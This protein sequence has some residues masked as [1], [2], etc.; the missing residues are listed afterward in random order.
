M[1]AADKAQNIL[2]KLE[3]CAEKHG[4]DIVDVE[5]AG[6]TKAP[7][8]RVRIDWADE[9]R[10]SISLDEVASETKWISEALDEFD[11]F[12]GAYTLEVS[13]PGLDRPLRRE[14]DF[15]RFAGSDVVLTTN[16]VEGRKK[17]T[18]KL[19]GL[20]DGKVALTADDGEHTFALSDIKRCCIKPNFAE[21]LKTK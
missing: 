5:C 20:R 9:S 19:E 8:V 7:V 21:L 12:S 4:V 16:A 10:D 2:D 14:K 1:A 15:E 17:F 6:A 11:P 3:N 18:G 13:S